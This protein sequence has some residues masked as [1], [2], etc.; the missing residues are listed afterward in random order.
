MAQSHATLDIDRVYVYEVAVGAAMKPVDECQ[1]VALELI[2]SCLRMLMP[3]GDAHL[4]LFC[5]AEFA[6]QFH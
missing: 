6:G 1:G 4:L 2:M 3:D 5:Q